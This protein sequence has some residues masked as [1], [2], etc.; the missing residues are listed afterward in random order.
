VNEGNIVF[1]DASASEQVAASRHRADQEIAQ[2]TELYDHGDW[3]GTIKISEMILAISP[4]YPEATQ[5]RTKAIDHVVKE[6]MKAARDKVQQ[7]DFVTAYIHLKRVQEVAPA[8]GE[9]AKLMA[10]V[11]TA[12]SRRVDVRSIDSEA[13]AAIKSQDRDAVSRSLELYNAGLK[14]LSQGRRREGEAALRE[15]LRYAGDNAVL[16]DAILTA[17]NEA[18]V[19]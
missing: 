10:T 12:L 11:D 14:Y 4:G 16:R 17:L 9:A 3:M 7:R 13:A 8:N 2:A 15:A 5:L 6:E 18:P 1:V 19:Q